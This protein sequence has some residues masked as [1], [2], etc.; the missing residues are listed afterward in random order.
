MDDLYEEE[1]VS[2]SK[3]ALFVGSTLQLD[4]FRVRLHKERRATS[5]SSATRIQS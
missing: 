3:V 5:G 4:S 2:S 1:V